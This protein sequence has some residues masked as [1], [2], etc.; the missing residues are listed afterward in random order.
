MNLYLLAAWNILKK[1]WP[2]LLCMGLFLLGYIHL[3]NILSHAY[4]RGKSDCNTSWQKRYDQL[5][6][7]NQL[8]TN[9]MQNEL[10]DFGKKIDQQNQVRVDKENTHTETIKEIIQNN[11][12]YQQCV[13]DQSVIDQR[14]QIRA[15][16]PK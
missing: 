2:V 14:N 12:V 8:L 5:V 9:V 13:I 6:A 1:M 16:G 7:Q 4:D 11:P 10:N 3:Q 15:L